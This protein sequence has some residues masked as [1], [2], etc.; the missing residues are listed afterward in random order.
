MHEVSLVQGLLEQVRQI[1]KENHADSVACIRVLIGPFSGVVLDS[2]S[3]AF[4][5]L[6]KDDV[7]FSQA[8]LEIQAPEPSFKCRYCQGEFGYSELEE[9]HGEISSLFPLPSTKCP[10]CGR[11]GLAPEGGDEILLMQVEME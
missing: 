7:L 2:F 11:H 9:E 8:L 6:K 3:F 5:V 4:D 10:G 1:A